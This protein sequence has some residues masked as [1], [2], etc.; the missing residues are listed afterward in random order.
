MAQLIQIEIDTIFLELA[1][2]AMEDAAAAGDYQKAQDAARLAHE[3]GLM[4]HG[5]PAFAIFLIAD[6]GA[7]DVAEMH[8]AVDLIKDS[9][10][11]LQKVER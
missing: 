6:Q 7:T 9:L 10:G 2:A 8:A 3:S 11:S 4:K 1:L 5:G